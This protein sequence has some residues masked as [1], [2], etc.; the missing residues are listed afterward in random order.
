MAFL[1]QDAEVAISHSGQAAGSS[2]APLPSSADEWLGCL[3]SALLLLPLSQRRV[4][5]ARRCAI[6]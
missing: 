6:R 1:A 2:F 5:N 3:V 4:R